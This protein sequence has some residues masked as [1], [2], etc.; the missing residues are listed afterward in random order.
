MNWHD[1]PSLL[2]LRAFEAA[3][4]HGSFSAAARDLNVTHAAIGQHVRALEDHFGLPLMY[5][6]GRG[7]AVTPD[8]R[9]LADSLSEAFSLIASASSD[10]L[11]QTKTRAIRVSLTPS[12]AANWLMPRIGGF[13]DTHPDIEVELIPSTRLIDLRRDNIDVAIRYGD[14]NWSGVHSTTLM[15]AGHSAVAA[16]SY[17]K[18]CKTDCLA[19]LKGSRWLLDGNRSEEKLWVA[20]NGVDL[21]EEDVTYFA[22]G[23]LSR[24]AALAGLGVTI[25]P[26]PVAAGHI[27]SGALVK[28]C[29]EHDSPFAYHVLTRP[30][31][32]SGPHDIFVKW[33]K[34]Q[35][36]ENRI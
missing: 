18:G 7:M 2:A 34:A 12:F 16:P 13:W 28:L 15:S 21:E 27:M 31:V 9:R 8:G 36:N 14:G 3:A 5:R 20:Q 6:E 30:E 29:E 17:L 1:I 19:D 35:S 33:L 26:A 4:R 22:T 32:V 25:L 23:Q 10:L 24:E 11:D